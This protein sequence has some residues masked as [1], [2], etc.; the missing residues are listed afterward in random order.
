MCR[1]PL[2]RLDG[3]SDDEAVVVTFYPH[4]LEVARRQHSLFW[5]RPRVLHC[6]AYADIQA[7]SMRQGAT[8]GTLIVHTCQGASV[9]ITMVALSTLRQAE[10][11]L[12]EQRVPLDA[13]RTE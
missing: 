11:L 3:V 5:Q 4:C 12:H 7:I 1:G 10:L 9:S 2:L 13:P 6:I 8:V